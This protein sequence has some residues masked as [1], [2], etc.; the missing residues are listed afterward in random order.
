MSESPNHR[1][2]VD[3]AASWT[4]ILAVALGLR[5]AAAAVVTWYARRKGTPCLF[6]DTVIYWELARTI[7]MGEPYRVFQWGVPHYA[8]R[9]PGYPLFLAA[10][11][12]VFGASLP[13]VRI[14]Q[15]GLGVVG[16]WLVGRL[17]ASTVPW[18][19]RPGWT[20]PMVAAG[21][22]A[23]EPYLVGMSALVLSE[24]LFLPVMLAGLW[25]LA[26]LWRR[27]DEPGP[28]RPIV[29]AVGAGLAMGAAVLARPSWALFLPAAL[30]SWV[31]GAGRGRRLEALR[32]ALI[33]G[34][35]SAAILAPWWVRNARVFG[36]FVPTAMWVGASLYDGINPRANG[37]SDMDFVDDPEF[38]TLGEPEQD[39]V[40][41]DRSIAFARSDPGRVL[42]L[43]GAKFGRFWS[44]WPNANVLK[45]PGVALASALVT[46]PVYVL[47]GLGA[48]DRRRDP[49]ALALLAGPLVYFCLLHMVFV[50]S[51]RY[52]IPGEVPALGL[53]AIGVGR[54]AG[55]RTGDD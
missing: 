18:A 52:R 28:K 20:I 50:S 54:L 44:P 17:T 34:L 7:V 41:R 31:I 4:L 47:I 45:A 27:G 39:A 19:R 51:V 37:E 29:V 15:A 13:A 33:V 22:A 14:V 30:A 25:A 43:A 8:L 2:A 24:A 55:W 5:L 40:F 9:T 48:W 1:R 35:A 42:A 36:K 3:R 23:V 12:E 49:K 16:V 10:C 11:R 32:G 26:S 53:A 6:G 21:I 46:I 38:R